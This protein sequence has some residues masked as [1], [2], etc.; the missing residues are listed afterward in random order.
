MK[1]AAHSGAH[2]EIKVS[3]IGVTGYTGLELLRVLTQHPFVKLQHLVSHSYT[4]KKISEVWPHLS[5]VCDL[6]LSDAPL[7]QVVSESDVVFLALPHGESQKIVPELMKSAGGAGAGGGANGGTKIIDL[8][9]DFRLQDIAVFEKFYGTQHSY[10]QG[11]KSFTYGFPEWQK[12]KIASAQYVANPGCFALTT[13]LAL[14]P[15]AGK[16]QDVSVVAVTGSSGSG[17]SPAEG[18]HH[19]VRSHN[20]KSYKIG[21]HQHIPEVL[22]STGLAES[23]M[24][25]V[26]TSGPFVRGIHLTATITPVGAI[27]AAGDT[28][29][30]GVGA[31]TSEEAHMIL[32][33]FYA[34]APFVRVKPFRGTVQ[35]ADII[36]SNF[37][38]ISVQVL[39]GKI[40]V[41]A[42]LDNLMKGASG[43]AV[44]NMNI[45]CGLPETTGLL[46][47]SPLLP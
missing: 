13:Q 26:P 14:L 38:D 39:N 23:Q 11:V 25:F 2:S 24:V 21:T 18:T 10:P 3:V 31:M 47:L 37:C 7:A 40:L 12:E 45:M 34:S 44:Q 8:A 4:G 6:S 16:I 17:K 35:L 5:G 33:K 42:V 30:A 29:G 36:G 27:G 1:F 41:Q 22:Q 32:T 43:S 19:P 28:T 46:T 9:G 15:F 20:M